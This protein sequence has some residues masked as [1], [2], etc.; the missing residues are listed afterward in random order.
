VSHRQFNVLYRAFLRRLIDPDLLP[1][2][3][4]SSRLVAQIGAL[5]ASVSFIVTLMTLPAF[6]GASAAKAAV[7]GWGDEEFLISTTLAVAGLFAVLA[8]DS[9][10]PDRRDCLVLGNFPVRPRTIF[11]AKLAATATGLALSVIAV[12]VA[13]GVAVPLAIG[14]LRA[15]IAYWAVTA[16]A[17]LF[18]FCTLMAIQGLAALLLPYQAFLKISNALQI[19]AFFVIVAAYFLTPG[20]AELQLSKGA[21]LPAWIGRLPSFWFVGLFELWSR[22]GL[23]VFEP[24]V[25]RAV[26]AVGVSVPLAGLCYLLSYFRNMRRIVEQPDIAPGSRA[27]RTRLRWGSAGLN[28]ALLLFIGRTMLR[29]RQHRNLLAAFGGLTLAISLAFAKVMLY[30][31]SGM[32]AKARRYGFR[33]PQW[34]QPNIPMITAGFVLLTLAILGTRTA[35]SIPATL[36]ANWMMRLTAVHSPKAYFYA[37]RRSVFLIAALPVL[38]PATLFYVFAWDGWEPWGYSAVLWAGAAIL[39]HRAFAGFNKHPFA[40]AYTP[41]ASN[42]R[43]KLPAM[44]AAFLFA[45]DLGANVEKSMLESAARTIVLG[46]ILTGLA[47]QARR[48]WRAFAGGPFEQLHFE[49]EPPAEVAPLRLG[50]DASYARSYRYLDVIHAPPEPGFGERF[51]ASL[52]KAAIVTAALCVCGFLYEQIGEARNPVPPRTGTPIDVGGRT[53]N[54]LC[55]GEGSPTVIFESGR[56]GPGISWARFQR[57]AALY[58]KACW[59]DRAGYGWSD[60]APFPHPASAIAAD[61]HRLLENARIPAPYVLVGFS[62]GGLTARV[63]AHRYPDGVAGMVLVDSTLALDGEPPTPPG[64]GYLPYF[65]SLIPNLARVAGH[66]GLLRLATSPADMNPF[67]PRTRMESAKEMDYESLLE[68]LDVTSLGDMPLI[69]LTA[70]KHRLS[71][72][73]N[74]IDAQRERVLEARWQAA[75]QKLALLSTRG[76]QRVFP[77]AD[78]NLPRDRPQDV[79]DA[80][81]EVA[82]GVRAR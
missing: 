47:L 67:E 46:A 58:T 44:A 12:N 14:G 34:N 71:P 8:W 23:G 52:R 42:L 68:S 37:I 36:S 70:G 21:P 6:V 51:A 1:A 16:A 79:M 19:A 74:P 57:D 20:P 48:K 13:S 53:L 54:Y 30:G 39:I 29:S 18:V 81:R 77:D 5:L 31:N 22:S 45:L 75:Q 11:G 40:C 80:V 72:P 28:R 2:R 50:G 82:Q 32:Y 26:L 73:D 60:P 15:L 64:G 62:F 63:F 69:V 59:Y 65:P 35:F 7:Q 33:P 38:I 41:G 55:Q 3:G 76:L 10:F 9:I 61:L 25:Q 56:G 17:A 78:H 43:V 66:L 24:L 27:W 49:D 4:D